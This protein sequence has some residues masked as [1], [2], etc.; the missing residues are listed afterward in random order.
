[1]I[2]VSEDQLSQVEYLIQQ[3]L[4][5]NHVL[6]DLECVREIF[7]RNVNRSC[8]FVEEDAYEVEPLIEKLILQPTL[9]QKRAFLEALD[10]ETLERVVR[11]YFNIVENN[12]YESSK[13][14]H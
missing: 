3:S 13:E 14:K 8:S 7:E 1:M 5:G 10:T 6:F 11:T 4:H 2:Y 12:L 9:Q